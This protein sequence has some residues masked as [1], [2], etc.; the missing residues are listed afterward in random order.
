M[1]DLGPEDADIADPD[2][3]T[4]GVPHATFR[5]LRRDDPVSW[6]D[7]DHAGARAF[8]PSRVTPTC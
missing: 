3:Y 8:G 7:D 2:T 1:N 6:W 4:A 5:R